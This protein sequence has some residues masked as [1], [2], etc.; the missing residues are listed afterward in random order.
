VSFVPPSQ[1][2]VI[3]SL[4]DV[5]RAIPNA[6]KSKAW[7]NLDLKHVDGVTI[8][9]KTYDSQGR[10]GKTSKSVAGGLGEN[11]EKIVGKQD[12]TH[13]RHRSE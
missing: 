11:N 1:G 2:K 5:S 12:S 3:G 7:L 10:S 8:V 4:G 13:W 6:A 9:R